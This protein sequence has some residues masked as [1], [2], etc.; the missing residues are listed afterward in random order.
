M[1][2]KFK[3]FVLLTYFATLLCCSAAV[4]IFSSV[5]EL[6]DSNNTRISDN[7][8]WALVVDADNDGDVLN[9]SQD[10]VFSSITANSL[11]VINQAIDI[12]TV[13]GGDEVFAL[14]GMNGAAPGIDDR[15]V[16]GI[17]IGGGIQTGR[18]YAFVWFPGVA[19]N[20]TS[21]DFTLTS[22]SHNIGTQ[23]GSYSS[24]VTDGVFDT[25]M[26]IPSD[27]NTVSAGALNSNGGGTIANSSLT[28]F[29][30]IPEPSTALLGVL[31]GL[32]LLR[33][34]RTED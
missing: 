5:G 24:S 3:S 11:F 12:G 21:G 28:A 14:G 17:T 23:V 32:L 4:G 6:F 19:F 20:G 18:A 34:R 27:G 26:F 10:S 29:D 16:N 1:C 8:L 33:R 9:T 2:M 31:G 22:N 13:L 25:G 15:L 7:T 30:L